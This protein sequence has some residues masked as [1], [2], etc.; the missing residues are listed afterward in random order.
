MTDLDAGVLVVGGGPA[1]LT[2]AFLLART[3]VPVVLVERRAAISPH[4]RA[5][6]LNVRTMELMRGWRLDD[7][8]IA[9]AG[10]VAGNS[11]RIWVDRLTGSELGRSSDNSAGGRD[12]QDGPSPAAP[13]LCPQHSVEAILRDSAAAAGAELLYGRELVAFERHGE[14]RV[15]VIA[16]GRDGSAARAP[17][18]YVLA[19]DGA[20]STARHLLGIGCAGP[21]A[22]GPIARNL[23]IY[24]R[25]DLSSYLAGRDILWCRIDNDRVNG[26]LM[27]VSEREWILVVPATSG[28][29]RCSDLVHAAIGGPADVE[30]LGAQCYDVTAGVADKFRAGNVFLL[31]DA[32]HQWPPAG[33]FGMNAGIQDAH[34]LAWKIAAVLDGWAG[35]GLL[36]SYEAERRPVATELIGRARRYFG[37]LGVGAPAGQRPDPLA[38]PAWDLSAILGVVYQSAACGGGDPAGPVV[39][40]Q[41]NTARIGARAPHLPLSGGGSVLDLFT[42]GYVLLGGPGADP[43]WTAA[44]DTVSGLLKVPLRARLIG[45]GRLDGVPWADRYGSDQRVVLVRPDGHLSWESA[46]AADPCV[47]GRVLA[48]QTA[49]EQTA[50]D[51]E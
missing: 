27:P 47:L 12:G 23:S 28:D 32:A 4:P 44:A 22:A 40:D 48:R 21:G 39:H 3:G 6:G 19:A 51:R 17:A 37:M 41:W 2:A 45:A 29:P 36:D 31:G 34:N 35:P 18:R 5:R 50:S 16:D 11:L 25:A 8:L 9:A 15:A 43:A 38:R 26:L 1:G 49:S 13:C 14:T 20:R 30:V 7:R 10:P 24:F 42:G 46:G 33:A